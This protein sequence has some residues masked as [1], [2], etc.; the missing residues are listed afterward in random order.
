MY[1]PFG[2]KQVDPAANKDNE[3]F[4]GHIDDD[5]TGLTYMQARYYD[6]NIGRFLSNDPVGFAQG[7]P[8]YFGRYM[9]VGNDPVNFTDPS[10]LCKTYGPRPTAKR[11]G[12]VI[13][14]TSTARR[15]PRYRRGRPTYSSLSG[16]VG[17]AFN[18]GG[19]PAQFDIT[20]FTGAISGVERRI[21]A[22]AAGRTGMTF[23]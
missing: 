10:G 8:G 18:G 2:L 19:A 4:T 21:M 15:D 5:A 16:L 23:F 12:C 11:P 20:R 22:S 7:G 1:S 14:G 17:H 9:Y 13:T 6:P 3:G